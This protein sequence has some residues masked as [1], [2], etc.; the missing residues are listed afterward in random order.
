MFDYIVN[1]PL[2]EK[3]NLSQIRYRVGAIFKDTLFRLKNQY[4]S[5]SLGQRLRKS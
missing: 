5:S 3:L 1:A 2:K 4:L